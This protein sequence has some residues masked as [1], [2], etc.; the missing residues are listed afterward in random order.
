V[1]RVSGTATSLRQ[2]WDKQLEACGLKAVLAALEGVRL[3]S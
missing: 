1:E 3:G 2:R